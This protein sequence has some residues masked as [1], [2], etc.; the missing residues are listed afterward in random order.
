MIDCNAFEAMLDRLLSGDR[1]PEEAWAADAHAASCERCRGL[2][3]I[4]RGESDLL[5][6][7]VAEELAG[8]I[9]RSTSGPAC[10]R[11]EALLCDLIDGRLPGS[12]V[13]LV[14]MHL[15]HCAG[16]AE[17]AAGLAALRADLPAMAELAP[18]PWFVRDVL[19][20]TTR[21]ARRPLAAPAVEAPDRIGAWG[22]RLLERPRLALELAYSAAM[23]IFLLSGTP[24]SP[25]RGVAERALAVVSVSPIDGVKTAYEGGSY[26]SGRTVSIAR[27]AWERTGSPLLREMEGS[28]LQVRNGWVSEIEFLSTMSGTSEK[29]W[30]AIWSGDLIEAG[31]I[32]GEAKQRMREDR[33]PPSAAPDGETDR[34]PNGPAP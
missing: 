28:W 8:E 4:A 33:E 16:C 25:L 27:G 18:D 21:R 9:L 19:D 34:T 31:R 7:G 32:L 6:D 24:G 29:I 13:E 30:R 12:D 15:E 1:T 23:V 5:G 2:L 20:A 11:S 26:L 10:A 22:R 3:A 14:T 17:L